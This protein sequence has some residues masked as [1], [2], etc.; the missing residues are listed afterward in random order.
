[1]LIFFLIASTCAYSQVSVTGTLLEKGTRKPL[2]E[3][4]I[5]LLPA[6]LKAVTDSEGKFIFPEV[7]ANSFE[8]I[9][10]NTGYIRFKETFKEA[11]NPL[12][13]YIE[14]EF[15]DV[16]ETVVT[17]SG[18]KK[19]VTKKSLSQ[20]EFLKAP[21]AQEDPVK[22]IQNL[23]GV[24]NQSFSSEIVI[25]GAAPDDTRYTIE[26]HEIPIVFHFGGLT[27]VVTPTAIESVDYLSAGYGPEYGRALGGIVNLNTRNAKTDRWHGEAFLDITKM[28]VL[29]EGPINDKSSLLISG[30][31]SYF[32]K[33]LE[34]ASEEIDEFA[35][36]SAPEFKDFYIK[37]NNSISATEE[38]S[39]DVI[40]SLDTLAFIVK[41]GED[42]NI[43]GNI[44]NETSFYRFIPT[45][46][47]KI[48]ENNKYKLSLG[49]GDD[50]IN[51]NIGDRYFDLDTST[52]SQRFEWEHKKNQ[53]LTQYY[54]I[55]SQY[56]QFRVQIRLPS[57]NG[58]GGVNTSGGEEIIADIKGDYWESA[59]YLRN[60][61]KYSSKLSFSPNIRGE[62]FSN[63]KKFY[64][65]PRFN[66]TY[67]L[68]S[69]IQFNIAFGQYYQA[70]Q[71]GEASTEF[72]NPALE[73]ERSDHLYASVS[74]DFREGSNQGVQFEVG[75]FYKNLENLITQT[76]E[77]R[78][79][80]TPVRYTNEGT[81]N[82]YGA[83]LQSSYK[84]GEYTVLASYTYLKS[85]RKDNSAGEYPS[86]FDQTHNINL[87]G[88]L[89]RSRWSYSTR[90]RYV[91]GGPYT[92]IVGSIYDT[93]RDI[94][95]PTR[96]DFYS[97]RFEDF[98]QLDLRIDRKFVY[99]LW[100]L[101]AYLDLQNVTNNKNGQGISYNFDYSESEP[102]TGIPIFPI[103]G[104]RGEF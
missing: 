86:E 58:Q 89:E 69:T 64:L 11:G 18:V 42:P 51:F 8:I 62:Y 27:S 44:S 37:Y 95:I 52:L 24:A 13:I 47:K 17:G 60:V 75:L 1:M 96:G 79:D 16:F 15:Y 68:D 40:S 19:D 35:V 30:R 23:P 99:K 9:I 5:F 78:S 63:I 14:K 94:Y 72:G 98:I 21:G 103:I 43:E 102:A 12:A 85:M 39:L 50:N 93:D 56:R 66:S 74:K 104:L 25:Q 3:V 81:G 2:S 65:M 48:D 91:S 53:K 70:P 97:K 82:V 67:N 4:N 84:Q 55:D 45:Y 92:P 31:I 61:Y 7:E 77:L 49:Y 59:A 10:N 28:G 76:S 41:E 22:A 32:G 34:K 71:N 54:G 46:S 20:K 36:T 33:I 29:A 88:V 26:G 90:L 80:G 57:F 6:K 73:S 100:L 38:F 101:S 83:Q 87:I